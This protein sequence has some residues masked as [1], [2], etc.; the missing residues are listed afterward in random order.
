M[1]AGD[2]VD[3]VAM[4]TTANEQSKPEV[5]PTI[6]AQKAEIEKLNK[7]VSALEGQRSQKI[8]QLRAGIEAVL[9]SMDPKERLASLARDFPELKVTGAPEYS[10]LIQDAQ[11][12]REYLLLQFDRQY[13]GNSDA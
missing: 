8:E 10:L 4:A 3:N 6:A 11:K 1:V 2:G 5:D 12:V 13:S 7:D 9:N